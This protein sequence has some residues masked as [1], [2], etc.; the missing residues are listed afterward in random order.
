MIVANGIVSVVDVS[1][2]HTSKKAIS[3]VI[4]A[5]VERRNS[6]RYINVATYKK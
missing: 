3:S 2:G 6:Q 5:V 4:Y 1:H